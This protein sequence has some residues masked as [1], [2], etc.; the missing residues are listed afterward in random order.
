MRGRPVAPW[1]TPLGLF[2]IAA[3]AR[4]AFLM[5]RPYGDEAHHYYIARHF[6]DG[7]HNILQMAD[8]HWLFWWRPMFSLL[9]SPGAQFGFTGFRIGYMLL[10]AGLAPA[11]WWWLRGRGVS[12]TASTMAGVVAALHPFLLLWGVRAFPDGLMATL[13]VL[14]LA[15]WERNRRIAGAAVLLAAVWTKEVALIGVGVLLLEEL[16]MGFRRADGFDLHLR[17]GPRHLLLALVLALA[18]VPH[19]YA[20]SLGG[21]SPGWS[22]GGEL[23]NV[24]DGAFTTAWFIPLVLAGLLW[25]PARRPALHALAY[26]AFYAVYQEVFG[27][28]AESWYF[29]LPTVLAVGAIAALIDGLAARA[30]DPVATKVD[31]VV[32]FAAAVFVAAI[33]AVQVFVPAAVAAKQDVLHHD[34]AIVEPSFEELARAEFERDQDLWTILESVNGTDREGALLVDVAWFFAIWP[35]SEEVDLLY[36]AYTGT[37]VPDFAWAGA[38]EDSANMTLLHRETTPLNE[39]I[40][41]V[42]ADCFGAETSE[43]VLI[44]GQACK[45]RLD[46]LMAAYDRHKAVA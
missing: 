26:L 34:T 24:L 4:L 22:R 21:R 9:L 30:Q 14:G 40:R 27:G 5:A 8:N 1:V 43:Y 29:F 13:Y 46:E 2:A 32:P 7:P 25:R 42:Y 16:L 6:G 35:M 20:E 17:L 11:L 36:S 18:Y 23:S 3:A 44:R 28:A 15:L 19:W 10:A 39:A 12:Q 38:I 45:G 31:R 33:L 41:E 37:A